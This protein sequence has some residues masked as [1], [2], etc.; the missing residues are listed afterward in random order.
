MSARIAAAVALAFACTPAGPTAPSQPPPASA[1]AAAEPAAPA[2]PPELVGLLQPWHRFDRALADASPVWLL[3]RYTPGTYPCRPGPDGSLDMLV[4]DRFTID[5]VVRG[6]VRAPAVD[7]PLPELSGPAFPRGWAEGRRYLLLLRPGPRA[8]AQLAD[9]AGPGGTDDR[10]EA[11]DVAG[12]VD[13]DV[14]RAAAE[15]EAVAPVRDGP[16]PWDS[17]RAAPAVDP[18]AAR[19]VV[20]ALQRDVLGRR[21]RLAEVRARL[22]PPDEVRLGPGEA[23]TEQYYLARP[24]RDVARHGAIY[25]DLRLTYDAGLELRAV[26]LFHLR[27]RVEP[28]LSS[29]SALTADEHAALGLP[30]LE[31]RW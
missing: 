25:G 29:S 15:A 27:W 6:D 19:A 4:Q 18:A 30:R 16:D 20:A 1:A 7:L 12:A 23:R 3:A 24:A 31:L 5:R 11:S 17:L 13:L 14:S 26:E 9:P 8:A 2:P 21:A 22:G 10:L 28:R